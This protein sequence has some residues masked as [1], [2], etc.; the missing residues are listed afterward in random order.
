MRAASIAF[1]IILFGLAACSTAANMTPYQ[2]MGLTGG[3]TVEESA[4]GTILVRALGNGFT[5]TEAVG[6]Y[7]LLKAAEL[8]LEA[9]HRC[10]DI[11]AMNAQM[12]ESSLAVGTGPIVSNKPA[13]RVRFRYAEDDEDCSEGGDAQEIADRLRPKVADRNNYVTK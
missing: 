4:D 5:P 11:I 13:A 1:G 6:D 2:N 10:M 3:V 7:A 9:G 8:T 12:E